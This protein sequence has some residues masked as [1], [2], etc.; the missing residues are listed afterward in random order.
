MHFTD[1]PNMNGF[2]S[3][4]PL[5]FGVFKDWRVIATLIAFFLVIMI[6]GFIANYS[7]KPPRPKKQKAAAPAPKAQEGEASEGGEEAA[8]EDD[9][10]E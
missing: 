8:A 9:T 2:K 10:A 7:K 5:V 6:A 1:K 4:F 3:F